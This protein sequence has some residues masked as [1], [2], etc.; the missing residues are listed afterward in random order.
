MM[1]EYKGKK[2]QKKDNKI[3]I[4]ER[5]LNIDIRSTSIKYFRGT[6]INYFK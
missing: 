1:E 6:R 3:N 2:K 4:F 5:K